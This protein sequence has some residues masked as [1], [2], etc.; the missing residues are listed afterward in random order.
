MRRFLQTMALAACIFPLLVLEA[1]CADPEDV[2]R[3]EAAAQTLGRM[4]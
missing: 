3:W 1:H 4:G 2:R